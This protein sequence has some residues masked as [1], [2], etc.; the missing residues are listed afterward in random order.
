MRAITSRRKTF[1][2][3]PLAWTSPPGRR[4]RHPARRASRGSRAP[5]GRAN[6]LPPAP[7]N[8]HS[9]GLP[10]AMRI[11]WGRLPL[12]VRRTREGGEVGFEVLTLRAFA[13]HAFARVE[14]PAQIL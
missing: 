3:Q 13:P 8:T 1:T 4:V 12:C 2:P 6:L 11:V 5:R 14:E 9:R 10:P 7:P